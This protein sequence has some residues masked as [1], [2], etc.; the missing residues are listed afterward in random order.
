MAKEDDDPRRK[1]RDPRDPFDELRRGP[2]L[3]PPD[4]DKR[5]GQRQRAMQDMMR[6][7]G[8]VEPGKPYVHGFSFKIGPDGKP[9]VS[10][11]GNRPQRPVKG[12]RPILSE[13]REPLTDVIEEKQQVAI[14]LE[15]PGVDKKDIDIRVTEDELE[16]NVDNA[17]RKY[18]K[19]LRMPSR[20][21]PDTTK[22]TYKN[23]ILDV[24]VQKERPSESKTGH[25]VKVE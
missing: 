25:K 21:K 23:G 12:E 4:S 11:F 1:A 5:F 16:I 15:L 2:G 19:L 8:G 9:Q 10:E 6:N 3:N 24:T 18:H 22:A 14:T 20:V 17:Q 13:E 7:F